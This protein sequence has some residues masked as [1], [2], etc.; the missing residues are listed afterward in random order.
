MSLFLEYGSIWGYNP[1]RENDSH[2]EFSEKFPESDNQQYI[3]LVNYYLIE[4]NKSITGGEIRLKD[5][6]N[7]INDFENH[8]NDLLLRNYGA[9]E[10]ESVCR[11]IESVCREIELVRKEIELVRREIYAAQ[12]DK[13][14]G[15]ILREKYRIRMEEYRNSF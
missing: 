8:I 9:D 10:I 12:N 6:Q 5:F 11:E 3:G 4:S 13:E 14:I 2:D 7:H 15:E 1:I